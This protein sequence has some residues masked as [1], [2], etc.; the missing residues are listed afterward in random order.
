MEGAGN[1]NKNFVGTKRA[2]RNGRYKGLNAILIVK[3]S[4]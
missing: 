3:L 4:G 2:Q 1:M